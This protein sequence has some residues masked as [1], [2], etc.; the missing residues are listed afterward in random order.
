MQ[1]VL[2]LQ[3]KYWMS[4]YLMGVQYFLCKRRKNTQSSPDSECSEPGLLFPRHKLR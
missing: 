1:N 2:L 3:F 4:G